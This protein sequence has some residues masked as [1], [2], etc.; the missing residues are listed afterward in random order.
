MKCTSFDKA[1]SIVSQDG[2][3]LS[4]SSVSILYSVLRT[5]PDVQT[6]LAHTPDTCVP[7]AEI[8]VS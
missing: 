7:T 6:T 5:D 8:H 2:F 1:F 4:P 3:H